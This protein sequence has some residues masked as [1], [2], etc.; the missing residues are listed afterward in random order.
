MRSVLGK[1]A[2]AGVWAS[3]ARP[4]SNIHPLARQWRTA[5]LRSLGPRF[6]SS[7]AGH[8]KLEENEG[9]LYVN[10]KPMF[11]APSYLLC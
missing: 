8:V 6:T 1:R 4:Q 2:L 11:T 10:S 9:L 7:H 5:P 3:L